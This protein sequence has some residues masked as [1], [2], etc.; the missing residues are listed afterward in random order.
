[1]NTFRPSQA[2]DAAQDSSAET[3][4]AAEDEGKS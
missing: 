2:S 1:M 4:K 3:R